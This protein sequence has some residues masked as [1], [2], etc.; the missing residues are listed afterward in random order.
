MRNNN[1]TENREKQLLD[2][3]ASL[4]VRLEES[5]EILEAIQTG[6]VDAL[7]V[8][9]PEGPQIYTIQGADHTYR[10]LI[11]EMNEGALILN[12]DA[13]IL[14][15]NSSFANFL[16]LPL[17]KVIG[18]TFYSFL[19][20]TDHQRFNTLF[21]QGWQKSSKGEFILQASSKTVL[22][23]SVS[24]SVLNTGDSSVLGIIVTDLSAEKEILAVKSQVAS[25]NQIIF[26]KEEELQRQ[27]QSKEEAERFR[28]V[29][30]GIPQ[31]AW[32]STPEGKI[33]YTNQFWHQYT[34]LSHADTQDDGWQS[35][36]HPDDKE[37]ILAHIRHC[38][39]NCEGINIEARLKRA[40][41]N[42][43]SWHIMRASPIRNADDEII[44]WVGTFTDIQDQKEHTAKIAK[45]KKDLSKL[46][47][48]LNTTNEQL[49]RTNNDLDTF[50][51]TASHDLKSPI[52]NI[53]GLINTLQKKLQKEGTL[54]DDS[55]RIIEMINLS[56][57]RFKATIKDLT[58][59]VKVQKAFEEGPALVSF[60]EC[61]KDVQEG[62]QDMID[63]HKA[64]IHLD[65][66]EF[67]DLSIS[68]KNL[69]SVIYNLLSN[70]I[71]YRSPDRA[72]EV[73]IK[74]EKQ[75]DYVLLTISDNGLGINDTDKNKIFEMF[76]RLHSHVDGTGIGLYIVKRIIENMGGKIEVEST[77][78][79]GSLFRIYLR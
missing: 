20:D 29:L 33:N 41:D 65:I 53:E 71:K 36:L 44:L 40:S 56:V 43:Y 21:K 49:I 17:E 76:K 1:I 62:I 27:K 12:S 3:I 9:G 38:F 6:A 48:E 15:C 42:S 4:K 70:A 2:E 46:N 69:K 58:E 7:T 59:I 64:T 13:T 37:K 47:T 34:N 18:S 28:V 39:D 51:Y 54:R 14:F 73:F 55:Q 25:Q 24:M 11:E 32:T 26:K 8:H 67:P 72:P 5:E 16:Q 10:V 31:I 52:L 45:A 23:F 60:E 63:E 79:Q 66:T 35:V 30:E 22:P 77:L 74:T 19:F 50:V 78:G 68:N 75:G 61:I 57:N